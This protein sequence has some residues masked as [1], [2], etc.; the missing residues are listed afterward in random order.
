MCAPELFQR[1]YVVLCGWPTLDIEEYTVYRVPLCAGVDFVATSVETCGTCQCLYLGGLVV[2]SGC[3]D[4]RC[5]CGVC[6]S[7]SITGIIIAARALLRFVCCEKVR[8]LVFWVR[9]FLVWYN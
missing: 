2:W 4:E 1:N 9:G 5:C 6:L 8:F 3:S 7:G